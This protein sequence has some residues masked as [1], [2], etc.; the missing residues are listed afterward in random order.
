MLSPRRRSQKPAAILQIKTVAKSKVFLINPVPH[1]PAVFAW[2]EKP[3]GLFFY[4]KER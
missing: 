2:P 3:L 1:P 4:A